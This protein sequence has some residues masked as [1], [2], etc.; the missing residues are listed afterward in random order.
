MRS[1]RASRR[2]C[3]RCVCYNHYDPSTLHITHRTHG[4][5]QQLALS[6]KRGRWQP[7]Y[8]KLSPEKPRLLL[9]K[10]IDC[11]QS[12]RR[13]EVEARCG[14]GPTHRRHLPHLNIDLTLRRQ[15]PGTRPDLSSAV[16]DLN[17]SAGMSR[18]MR[19]SLK[20]VPG[21]GLDSAL[22]HVPSQT[23]MMRRLAASSCCF[24]SC[25]I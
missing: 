1:P 21:T 12:P 2:S 7:A 17:M 14:P 6:R 18:S 9:F 8:V 3:A 23:S 25:Q 16:H 10:M 5:P 22:C 11:T 13:R 20:Q 24:S 4:R 19:G 15:A